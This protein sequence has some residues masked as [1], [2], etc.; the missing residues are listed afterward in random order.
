[1]DKVISIFGSGRVSEGGE[2]FQLAEQTGRVLAEL[3]FTVANGGYGGTM[4]GSARGAAKAGGRTVG[5]TCSAFGRGTANEYISRE[6]LTSTLDERLATLIELGEVYI[7]LPG[8]TGTLLEF[9][10]VWELKNKGF[11]NREKLIILLGK[12]W[13]PVV[14]LMAGEDP[15]SVECLIQVDGAEQIKD[16]LRGNA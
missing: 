13:K 16:I 6:I 9:A 10:K 11:F 5:V 7:V 8:G 14:D 15:E 2:I 1:M 4:L 3:G 12:Y